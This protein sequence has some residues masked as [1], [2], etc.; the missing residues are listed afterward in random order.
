MGD[1]AE[2]DAAP[3]MLPGMVGDEGDEGLPSA[4]EGR[5]PGEAGSA[6]KA[7]HGGSGGEGRGLRTAGVGCSGAL[8]WLCL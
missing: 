8:A 5:A 6:G 2:A 1:E 3:M 7:G 4:G